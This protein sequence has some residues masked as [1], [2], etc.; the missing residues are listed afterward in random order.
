MMDCRRFEK[1]LADLDRPG[2][3]PDEL[4]E[5]ALA[6][7][8]GCAVCGQSLTEAESLDT[9]LRRLASREEDRQPPPR[10]EAQL[11]NAFRQR[12]AAVARETTWRYASAI[13][14]AAVLLLALGFWLSGRTTDNHGLPGLK[15]TQPVVALGPDAQGSKTGSAAAHSGPVAHTDARVMGSQGTASRPTVREMASADALVASASGANGFIP[16]P[17]ADPGPLD[18]GAVVRVEMPRAAL[19]TLGLPVEA[20]E[21]NGTV[22]ADLV[23]SADGTPEAIRLLS[24]SDSGAAER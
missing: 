16:L 24:Q 4:R 18:D 21:G 13:A 19:A 22:R 12:N 23:V 3:L 20:M 6:H 15:V 8:E 17:D 1:L 14:I 11:L 10:A 2:V 7:A 5:R 9:E